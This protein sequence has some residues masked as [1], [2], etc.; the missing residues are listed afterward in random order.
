MQS[1][2]LLF[3]FFGF[4]GIK[5][6]YVSLLN[7]KRGNIPCDTMKDKNNNPYFFGT[8]EAIL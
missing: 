5:F 2:I 4:A 3:I 6:N 1:G 8:V 7:E